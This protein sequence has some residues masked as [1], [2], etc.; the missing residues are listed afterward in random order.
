MYDHFRLLKQYLVHRIG[1]ANS[2]GHGVHSPF[3]F[4]FIQRVLQDTGHQATFDKPEQYRLLLRNDRTRFERVDLGA[5]SKQKSNF[6]TVR[7]MA[8]RSLQQA[9]W[10]RLLYRMIEYYRP[11]P[12][13]ELGTSF[14]VT[15]EYLSLADK[16]QS[17]YTLEGDPF[18]ARRAS[19]QFQQDDLTQIKLIEGNFDDTL[20]LV[21][22]QMGQIGFVWLDGNHRKEPTLRYVEQLIP[23][24]HN[25]S[26][27]V[28]DDIYWSPSMQAAWQAIQLH[29]NVTAT[30]DLFRMGVVLFRREFHQKSH[31]QLHY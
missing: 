9:K 6:V 1:A 30:I 7:S 28:L 11:G 29:T 22:A 12:V 24:L 14:G 8:D 21:S 3:F 19:M 17:V 2:K 4:D 16:Q 23:Y 18:I 13:L 27:L 15:T 10:A 5:G 31:I 20:P 26:I 25:D